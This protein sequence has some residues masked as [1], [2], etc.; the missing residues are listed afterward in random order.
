MATPLSECFA[1]STCRII[2]ANREARRIM[3]YVQETNLE[4]LS[5]A[6]ATRILHRLEKTKLELTLAGIE[7]SYLYKQMIDPEFD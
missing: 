3:K 2:Y 7:H 5:E 4:E 6:R 1:E